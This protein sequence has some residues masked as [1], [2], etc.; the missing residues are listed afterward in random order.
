MNKKILIYQGSKNY[1]HINYKFNG[2][3]DIIYTD[4]KNISK[5]I[6]LIMNNQELP[7]YDVLW[8]ND[9][10]KDESK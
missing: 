9:I 5:S 7:E 8:N 10:H 3:N 2:N 1:R 6:D 4:Q